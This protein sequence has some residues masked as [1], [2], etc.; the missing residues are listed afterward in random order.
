MLGFLTPGERT[1]ILIGGPSF[2]NSCKNLSINIDYRR[3]RQ[4]FAA[5][6][7]LIRCGFYIGQYAQDSNTHMPALVEWLS[8]NG[9]VVT[10]RWLRGSDA[11]PGAGPGAGSGGIH[12]SAADSSAPV[13][14][15]PRI[16]MDVE[17][18][19]DTV[20]LSRRI[21]HIVLFSH[22]GSLRAAVERA[23]RGGCR[24]TLVSSV[25]VPPGLVAADEDLRRQVDAFIE[26]NDIQSAF[27]KLPR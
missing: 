15:K 21:D 18:A 11:G 16:D 19:L 7:N 22:A 6:C 17:M 3:L 27:A 8:L 5:R 9:Y 24:I 20:E 12:E 10:S 4:S 14:R 25:M 1:A 26:I 23:Q 13:R 2:F